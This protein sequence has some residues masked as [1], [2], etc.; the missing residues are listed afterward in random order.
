MVGHGLRTRRSMGLAKYLTPACPEAPP[1]ENT[2]I[3][4]ELA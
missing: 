4:L 3:H 1:S 2:D